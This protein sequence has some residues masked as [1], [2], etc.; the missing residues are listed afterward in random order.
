MNCPPKIK[1]CLGFYKYFPWW[2]ILIFPV[3][4][5]PL[6]TQCNKILCVWRYQWK[7]SKFKP[8]S[9]MLISMKLWKPLKL[10]SRIEIFCKERGRLPREWTFIKKTIKTPLFRFGNIKSFVNFIS[11]FNNI[12][13]EHKKFLEYSTCLGMIIVLAIDFLRCCQIIMYTKY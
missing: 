3:W 5:F 7:I 10:I 9:I 2:N 8:I 4:L 6:K 1:W 11:F 13:I 12:K